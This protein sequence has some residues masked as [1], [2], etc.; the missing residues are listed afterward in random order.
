VPR[1]VGG[2]ERIV[3]GIQSEVSDDCLDRKGKLVE[4]DLCCIRKLCCEK[5]LM[6]FIGSKVKSP[7]DSSVLMLFRGVIGENKGLCSKEE[8]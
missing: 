8:L 2:A 1:I 5:K 4:L 6:G 3:G 7:I